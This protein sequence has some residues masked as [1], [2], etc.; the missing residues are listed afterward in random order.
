[1]I[2]VNLKIIDISKV[3]NVDGELKYDVSNYAP[4]RDGKCK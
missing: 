3:W 2:K 4:E 1:M